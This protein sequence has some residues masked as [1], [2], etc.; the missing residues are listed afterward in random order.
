[1]VWNTSQSA[2]YN[3]PRRCVERKACAEQKRVKE[4]EAPRPCPP[5]KQRKGML[6]D[7]DTVLLLV[8]L[9]ILMREKSDQSLIMALLFAMLM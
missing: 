2:L 8:L 5:K 4:P 6:D 1:M 7:G 9:Y 3:A